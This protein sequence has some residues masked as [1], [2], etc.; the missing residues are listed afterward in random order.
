M[1]EQSRRFTLHGFSKPDGRMV[2]LA[3]ERDD[4]CKGK[5]IPVIL[6]RDVI[7]NY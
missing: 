7:N 2:I 1:P 4:S 5:Q 3:L 6:A